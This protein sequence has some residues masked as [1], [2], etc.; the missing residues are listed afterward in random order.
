M[1]TA[2][3]A[4]QEFPS[5]QEI[6]DWRRA[7]AIDAQGRVAQTKKLGYSK[8][9]AFG[10]TLRGLVHELNSGPFV[11]YLEQLTGIEHLTPDPRNRR[12]LASIPARRGAAGACGFQSL[13]RR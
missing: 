4:E 8:E 1:S 5:P 3:L 6:A 12:R 13:V 11:R 10:P 7:D 2:A 9:E